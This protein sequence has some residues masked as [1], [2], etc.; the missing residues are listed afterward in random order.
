MLFVIRHRLLCILLLPILILMIV[1]FH[2]NSHTEEIL[3]SDLKYSQCLQVRESDFDL[4]DYQ[5]LII[6]PL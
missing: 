6:N 5:K 4:F 1:L 3:Y 2:H